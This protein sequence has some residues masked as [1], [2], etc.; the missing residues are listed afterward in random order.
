MFD[1]L[2]ILHIILFHI[3][4]PKN[5]IDKYPRG[6][7]NIG[8]EINRTEINME[9]KVVS[10]PACE[11]CGRTRTRDEKELRALKNRLSRIEGQIRG[12]SGMVDSDAYC[13]DILTQVS[14]VQAAISSFA[15]ELLTQHIKGCVVNDIKNDKLETAEELAKTVE[16][17]MR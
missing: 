11:C 17:L 7:Y 6:V 16:K 1:Y 4:S 15:S 10:A 13:V 2:F 14:A 3:Y 9:E 8:E 5:P 12:I